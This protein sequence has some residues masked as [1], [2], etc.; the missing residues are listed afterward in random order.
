MGKLFTF[1]CSYT[2]EFADG[3]YINYR[4][5]RGGKYPK[6]W[7]N[8]L[9]DKLEIPFT[10]YGQSASSNSKILSQFCKHSSEI[11]KGD[12]VIIEWSYMSRFRWVNFATN[13]WS[14]FGA[15]WFGGNE[16]MEKVTFNEIIHNR[17]H[18]RYVEELYDYEM[19]IDSYAKAKDFKVFYWS[20]DENV[21]NNN[22]KRISERKYLCG[23]QIKLNE[24]MFSPVFEKGGQRISEETNGV[25]NDL[26][27]GETAHE[28][29]ADLFY[30]YITNVKL[31]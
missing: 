31:I 2:A 6:T 30:E 9:A 28:V 24:T 27:F 11:E 22:P 21:I 13:G 12:I 26:H 23:S 16:M 19:L 4:K 10:N 29:M 7:V 25:I 8:H 18:K 15:G 1:G 14:D 3:D 17:S 20:C 5:W